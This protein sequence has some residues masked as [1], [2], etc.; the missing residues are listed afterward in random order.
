MNGGI[1]SAVN[2]QRLLEVMMRDVLNGHAEA[3]SAHEQSLQVMSQRTESEMGAVMGMVAVAVA[4]TTTLQNQ[5]VC[6]V[7]L[8][9][10]FVATI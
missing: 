9:G 5:I 7:F 6:K 10:L 2:L 4:S 8:P 3:A 1:E